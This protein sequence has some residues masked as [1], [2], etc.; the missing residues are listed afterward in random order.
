[1]ATKYAVLSMGR[2]VE[3]DYS[4]ELCGGTHVNALGD[5][6]H[7]HDHRRRRRSPSGI[8]RIEALTGETARAVAHRS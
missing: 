8:R 2:D 4:V 6:R 5:I 3:E 1:M 7:L